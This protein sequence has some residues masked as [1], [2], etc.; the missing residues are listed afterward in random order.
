MLHAIIRLTADTLAI[1]GAI[2]FSK[3]SGK[4]SRTDSKGNEYV[5][6]L[7]D[8]SEKYKDILRDIFG[9]KLDFRYISRLYRLGNDEK[10]SNYFRDVLTLILHEADKQNIAVYLSPFFNPKRARK[11]Q[12]IQS[13]KDLENYYR[14]AG[15]QFIPGM[16]DTISGNRLMIRLP[17]RYRK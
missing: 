11:E 7:E 14:R 1:E 17:K 4:I 5:I 8:A 2:N 12:K 6:V 16:R 13:Q 3:M 10:L 9:K 15:F